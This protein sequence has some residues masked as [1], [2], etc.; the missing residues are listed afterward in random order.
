MIYFAS[1][2]LLLRIIGKCTILYLVSKVQL[3]LI[4]GRN[5]CTFSGVT[6]EHP[7]MERTLDAVSDDSPSDGEVCAQMRAVRVHHVRPTI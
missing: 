6:V 2:L 3:T 4:S 1:S 5:V 7:T